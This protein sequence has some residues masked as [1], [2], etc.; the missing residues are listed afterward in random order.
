MEA[1]S[2]WSVNAALDIVRVPHP[3]RAHDMIAEPSE[4][5]LPAGNRRFGTRH[6]RQ[7]TDYAC[8]VRFNRCW[9]SHSSRVVGRVHEKRSVCFHPTLRRR[10]RLNTEAEADR[11]H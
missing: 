2:T 5:S 1:S 3:H 6:A 4:G 10:P 11:L 8:L 7:H 9:V